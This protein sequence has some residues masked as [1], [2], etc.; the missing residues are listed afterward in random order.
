VRAISES[1]DMRPKYFAIFGLILIITNWLVSTA[2]A[3]T[4]GTTIPT[5]S[6]PETSCQNISISPENRSL[7]AD[8][9]SAFINV[10]H[11]ANCTFTAISSANWIKVTSVI[12]GTDIGTVYYSVDA[13]S[14]STPRS[15]TISIGSRTFVIHQIPE[16]FQGA[17]D[18]LWTG[19][20]HTA[21]INGVAFSPDGQLLASASSD[22]TVKVWRVADGALLRTLTGFYDSVTSVTFSHNGQILA[23]GSIDRSV[24]AW[25]VNDWS[26]AGSEGTGDFMF[27]VAFS[28]NDT[29]LAAAGGYSGNW[30][31]LIRTSD[32]QDL[33]LLGPGQ[34]QNTSIAYSPD[35]QYLAW[36]IAG[37][38]VRLQRISTGSFCMLSEGNYYAYTVNSVAFSPNGQ[39]LASG[40]D[41]QAVEIWQ[42][43]NCAESQSLNGPAGF[44]KSVA[45]A[46]NGQFILSGG[47]DWNASRGALLFWRIAD[48][49]LMRVYIGETSTAVLAVQY[50]PNGNVF[51][52]GRADGLVVFARNPFSLAITHP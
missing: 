40:S 8:G 48:G 19:A 45:Y 18:I 31:H 29:Q 7:T 20:G 15:G 9:G 46:P 47:Q 5:A 27:S 17:P 41:G 14:A 43:A 12:V 33:A 44:V 6:Q 22:H 4:G 24:K 28:P 49:A 36:A 42:V 52:Y 30:I 2:F 51:A 35:G 3:Q 39:E 25:R 10:D 34:Q 21:G 11:E 16:R 1:L 37:P 26:L 50:S 38:G 23:A 32:W 13:Y